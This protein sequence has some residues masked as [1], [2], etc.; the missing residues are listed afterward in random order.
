MV[1]HLRCDIL[2]TDETVTTL[3]QRIYMEELTILLA[4]DNEG[5]VILTKRMLQRANIGC[6]LK[7]VTDGAEA[8]DCL[9]GNSQGGTQE[10]FMPQVVL[11]DLNMPKK[12]GLEVLRLIRANEKTK[13]L[14]V[15]IQTSSE[16]D[17]DVAESHSLGANCYIRKP[18][19][20]SEFAEAMV[21]LGIC[22]QEVRPPAAPE[23]GNR[24]L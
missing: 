20:F 23:V 5:D 13:S 22:Y 11:L 6:K 3:T 21:R 18:I 2:R 7:V 4:E 24:Q 9:F 1:A 10:P 8:T 16:D 14:P 12:G 15:I 17:K 19:D